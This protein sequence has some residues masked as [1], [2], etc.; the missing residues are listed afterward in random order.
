MDDAAM[1]SLA[2]AVSRLPFSV[3]RGKI[4]GDVSLKDSLYWGSGWL[5]DDTPDAFQ[6]YLSP[7]M[8]DKGVEIGRAHV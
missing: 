3:I 6:P 4:Y 7:L 1:D 5:W 8:L 2:N